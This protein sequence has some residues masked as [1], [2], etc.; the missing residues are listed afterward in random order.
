MG[1][2]A[3][4]VSPQPRRVVFRQGALLQQQFS[5]TVED[6]YGKG[7]M[8]TR[9]NMGGHLLHDADLLILFVDEDYVFHFGGFNGEF[10]E[11]FSFNSFNS[12]FF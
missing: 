6:E 2:A 3:A 12:P 9:Y 1:V 10:Y 4:G 7:A 11:L 5:L 8:E